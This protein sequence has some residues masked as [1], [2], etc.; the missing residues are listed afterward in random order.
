M[1]SSEA[2]CES[3]SR[4]EWPD[5]TQVK[6]TTVFNCFY[7]SF[8]NKEINTTHFPLTWNWSSHL[9]HG[10][11]QNYRQ[12]ISTQSTLTQA[13]EGGLISCRPGTIISFLRVTAIL[14]IPLM[15]TFT[16]AGCG[17]RNVGWK[18]GRRQQV[19]GRRWRRSIF[20][21][22]SG[23]KGLVTQHRFQWQVQTGSCPAVLVCVWGIFFKIQ[24]AWAVTE[25]SSG[26]ESPLPRG[27]RL[28]ISSVCCWTSDSVTADC[29]SYKRQQF[30]VSHLSTRCF[31]SYTS[32]SQRKNRV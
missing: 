16:M 21:E 6:C 7:E 13:E 28:F 23:Q 3:M 19:R 4:A 32:R 31:I 11:N 1:V 10:N 30:H 9:P 20:T 22:S 26:I 18:C 5:F 12:L 24:F 8:V 14:K 17:S 15:L 25:P 27:R 29:H 2:W